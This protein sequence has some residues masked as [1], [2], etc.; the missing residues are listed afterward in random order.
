MDNFIIIIF[1]A[2]AVAG[3]VG[4]RMV[5]ACS[6]RNEVGIVDLEPELEEVDFVTSDIPPEDELSMHRCKGTLFSLF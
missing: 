5:D 3:T 2:P 4:V 1:V 6:Q